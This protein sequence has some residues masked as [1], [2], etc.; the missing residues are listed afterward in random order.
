MLT[1]L[2]KTLTLATLLAV[3]PKESLAQSTYKASAED[4]KIVSTLLETNNKR[5]GDFS[6]IDSVVI[7]AVDDNTISSTYYGKMYLISL[8]IIKS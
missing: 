3:T 5:L 6:A 4:N 7:N 8:L 1:K 2:L